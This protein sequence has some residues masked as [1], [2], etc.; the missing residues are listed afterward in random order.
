MLDSRKRQGLL[1]SALLLIAFLAPAGGTAPTSFFSTAAADFPPGDLRPGN[2]RLKLNREV[3]VLRYRNQVGVGEIQVSHS[4]K[5]GARRATLCLRR[6][7]WQNAIRHIGDR[8]ERLWKVSGSS[9]AIFVKFLSFKMRDG[10]RS[11]A[12]ST[13]AVLRARRYETRKVRIKLRIGRPDRW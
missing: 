7:R 12:Y 5:G 2:W 6:G 8:C 4:G 11:G 10:A 1:A 9:A 3:P 13:R